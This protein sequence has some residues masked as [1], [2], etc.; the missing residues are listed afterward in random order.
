MG[1]RIDIKRKSDICR[2]G[3]QNSLAADHTGVVDDD[4]GVA[5][6]ASYFLSN[7]SHVLW[8]P[9]VAVEMVDSRSCRNTQD[10]VSSAMQCS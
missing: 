1:Q 2:R 9:D 8:R 10:T 6:L 5:D 7:S 4:T 3:I